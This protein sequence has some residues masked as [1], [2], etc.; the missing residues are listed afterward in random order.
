MS[1]RVI[2]DIHDVAKHFGGVPAVTGATFSVVEGSITALIGPNGAGKTSLFNVISGFQ[3]ADQGRVR[4]QGQRIDR[5]PTYKIARAGLVRT[6]QNT[7]ILRRMTVLDNMLLAGPSQ[8][9]E[10]L[11]RVVTPR[12]SAR[13][14][15]ELK[16]KAQEVLRSVKLDSHADAYAGTLSGG[17]RKLLEFARALMAEPRMLLLDE[18]MAGVN[19]ALRDQ[20]LE[21]ILAI[22]EREGITFLLIEHDLETV[23]TISD[24]VAVMSQGRVIFVGSPDEAQQSEDV[25]DAYLGSHDSKQPLRPLQ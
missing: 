20:L 9:G 5:L 13:R 7:K 8:P 24:T 1:E 22:R 18:P 6:F 15:R 12:P 19:P 25:I 4:F 11:W 2:L 21:Q 16:V 23:M 10:S 3:R 14:E 17:Q